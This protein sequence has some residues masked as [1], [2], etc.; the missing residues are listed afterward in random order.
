MLFFSFIMVSIR[1][2]VFTYYRESLPDFHSFKWMEMAKFSLS[3]LFLASSGKHSY[4]IVW[5]Y[6]VYE[7]KIFSQSFF[8][9]AFVSHFTRKYLESYLVVFEHLVSKAITK[10]RYSRFC[11]IFGFWNLKEMKPCYAF[12]PTEGLVEQPKLWL[13]SPTMELKNFRRGLVENEL[14][15]YITLISH[16]SSKLLK[17]GSIHRKHFLQNSKQRFSKK[18]YFQ[19]L[20]SV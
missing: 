19:V 17:L 1:I 4:I 7:G 11:N 14:K 8:F 12:I 13:D 18:T 6:F 3:M 9:P 16:H 5:D 2:F 20:H 10:S 15:A